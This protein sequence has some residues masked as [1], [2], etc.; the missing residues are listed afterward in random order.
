VFCR[1]KLETPKDGNR[2]VPMR[3]SATVRIGLQFILSIVFGS[4]CA[5]TLATRSAVPI[6]RCHVD[7]VLTFSDRPCGDAS[8]VHEIDLDGINTSAAPAAR[9]AAGRTQEQSTRRQTDSAGAPGR[10]KAAQ[11]CERLDQSLKDIRS[12]MRS[13]YKASEGERLKQRQA[14]LKNQLRLARCS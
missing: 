12:K 3:S 10:A 6:H 4:L 2:D 13:G 8:D 11:A 9:N 5:P 7:G 14:K 1:V